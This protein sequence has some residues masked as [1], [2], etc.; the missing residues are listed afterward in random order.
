MT[1][2]CTPLSLTLSMTLTRLIEIMLLYLPPYS[3]DQNPIEESF[4]T[5]KAYLRRHGETLQGHDDPIFILLDSLGCIT[6]EMALNWFRH[7]GYI[8]H[9]DIA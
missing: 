5:W 4:S 2:V 7:A 6:S 8:V 1:C 3:P 9:D